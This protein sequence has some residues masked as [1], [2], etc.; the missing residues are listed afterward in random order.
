MR[1]QCFPLGH[2]FPISTQA[3]RVILP[4]TP[5][6]SLN[7]PSTQGSFSYTLF[8]HLLPETPHL[9]PRLNTSLSMWQPAFLKPLQHSLIGPWTVRNSNKPRPRLRKPMVEKL[10]GVTHQHQHRTINPCWVGFL[11]QQ[12]DSKAEKA[13]I[14]EMACPI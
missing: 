7:L 8:L 2:H 13:D 9:S 1:Q 10:R 4:A 12:P 11:R 6:P 14:L 3:P 5:T